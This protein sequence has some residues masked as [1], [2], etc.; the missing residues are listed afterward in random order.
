MT[1]KEKTNLDYIKNIFFNL[2]YRDINTSNETEFYNLIRE[3]TDYDFPYHSWITNNSHFP[4]L[5]RDQFFTENGFNRDEFF[6]QFNDP[7]IWALAHAMHKWNKYVPPEI[8]EI[9]NGREYIRPFSIVNGRMIY[10]T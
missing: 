1:N 3:S 8:Y 9:I 10:N 5:H 7:N 2:I 6:G 4:T